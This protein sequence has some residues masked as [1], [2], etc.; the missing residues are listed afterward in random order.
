MKKI[1]LYQPQPCETPQYNFTPL[2]LLRAS[3]ILAQKNYPVVIKSYFEKDREKR[4]FEEAK[5]AICFGI[6]AISGYQIYDGLKMA[7][8]IRKNFPDLPI[9]WGGWHPTILPEQTIKNEYVDIIVRGQGEMTFYELV[10]A[11]KNKEPLE[12]VLGITFKKAQKIIST[13]D[14]PIEPFENLP[15]TPYYLLENIKNHIFNSE[16]GPRSL[17]YTSSYGCPHNCSFCVQPA[18]YKGKWTGLPPERVVKELKELVKNYGVNG[19]VVHEDNFFANPRRV[20]EIAGLIIEN[21]LKINW[22]Q[23]DVRPDVIIKLDNETLRL[24]KQSGFKSV[25]IGAES[26]DDY[27]LGVLKKGFKTGDVLKAAR[28]LKEYDIWAVYSFMLG[29][30]VPE[31]KKESPEKILK[32]EF[33]NFLNF[34]LK[35]HRINPKHFILLY[36]FTPLPKTQVYFEAKEMGYRPPQSLEEWSEVT[37]RMQNVPWLPKKY[38]NFCEMFKFYLPLFGGYAQDKIKNRKNSL[39]R[40]FL[41]ASERVLRNLSHLRF[42]YH[43]FYFPVEYWILKFLYKFYRLG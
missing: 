37:F 34:V 29:I 12:N 41:R 11:L 31:L 15:D 39:E 42:K 16:F 18:I 35:L 30:P 33:N 4:I 21:N 43:F 1:I 19:I 10:K 6:T 23:A 28:I 20:K 13:P 14:R 26:G 36:V 8:L 17:N 3:S 24:L 9:V 25:L 32:E 7:K 40:F 38:S 5:E 27:R 2:S 22:G